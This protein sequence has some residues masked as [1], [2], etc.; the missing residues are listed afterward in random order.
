M[1]NILCFLYY[2][3]ADFEISLVCTYLNLNENIKITYISYDKDFVLSSAGLTIKPDLT[4]KEALNIVNEIDG[5]IIPGG[6][7]RPFNLELKGLIRKLNN[8][9]KLLAAICAGPEFLAKSGIL[10]NIKYTA[11]VEPQE[12]DEKNELDPFPRDNY[13]EEGMVRDNNIITAKGNAFIDF[14]L[15]IFEWFKLYDY[16]DEREECKRMWSPN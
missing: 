3:Y 2:T 6:F 16:E 11:A 5:L 12:Y 13:L 10:E 1:K 7:E 14:T 8:R 9:N 15:E 4:V